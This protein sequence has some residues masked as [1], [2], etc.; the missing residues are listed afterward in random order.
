MNKRG[1]IFAV[2][3]LLFGCNKPTDFQYIHPDPKMHSI[4]HKVTELTAEEKLDL[5][6]LIGGMTE[7][8]A[9]LGAGTTTFMSKF[10]AKNIDWR[11]AVAV[12]STTDNSGGPMPP[13][14]GMPTVFDFNTP[15]PAQTFVDAVV[16]AAT[17]GPDG[18][19]IFD[20]V[21]MQLQKYPGFMRKD[22]TLAIIMTNDYPDGSATVTT[23]DQMVD[24]LT[25]LKGDIRQVVV[26]GVFG[27]TELGCSDPS[28]IDGPWNFHGTEMEKLI[29]LTGG[30]V[31]SLCDDTFGDSLSKIGDNLFNL[32]FH[33]K[34]ILSG[35]ADPKTIR[36]LFKGQ[37]LPSGPRDQGGVWYYDA[38]ENSVNFYNAD[39]A[40]G[41]SDEVTVQY[42][43]YSPVQ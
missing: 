20:P 7:Q 31:F 18:E 10:M 30:K 14:L 17:N 39:F 26:Y 29:N 15:N 37:P 2:S 38:T 41:G 24:I 35:K 33:P 34:V 43:E 40:G 32:I 28:K 42:E 1:L 9:K 19:V 8:A 36:V 6:W 27:A 16:N 12:N 4:T 3:L 5:F 13:L 25:K 22:V 11:M 23:A 21:A